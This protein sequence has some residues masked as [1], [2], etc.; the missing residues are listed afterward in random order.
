MIFLIKRSSGAAAQLA[1]TVALI[2]AINLI[3]EF[4]GRRDTPSNAVLVYSSD[5]IFEEND[6]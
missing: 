4:S 2:A 5:V 6:I 1:V 3:C